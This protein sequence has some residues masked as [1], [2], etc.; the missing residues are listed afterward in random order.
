MGTLVELALSRDKSGLCI[1]CGTPVEGPRRLGL[2]T[3][4]YQ[5]F[6]RAKSRQP[7]DK[8]DAWI[9]AQIKAGQVLP[10][11][12]RVVH[13]DDRLDPIEIVTRAFDEGRELTEEEV[14]LIAKQSRAREKRQIDLMQQMADSVKKT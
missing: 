5:A 8:V 6:R 3:S 1:R 2:C 13:D 9:K 12:E 14:K 7:R 10:H 4:H 11:R